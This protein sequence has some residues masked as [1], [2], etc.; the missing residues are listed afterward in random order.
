MLKRNPESK[1]AVISDSKAEE[2]GIFDDNIEEIYVD[3]NPVDIEVVDTNSVE[4]NLPNIVI[5]ANAYLESLRENKGNERF[6]NVYSN[7]MKNF[8]RLSDDNILHKAASDKTID[9][10]N[11]CNYKYKESIEQYNYL[12]IQKKLNENET[13]KENLIDYEKEIDFNQS[14]YED[15]KSNEYQFSFIANDEMLENKSNLISN[16]QILLIRMHNDFLSLKNNVENTNETE[17]ISALIL[18]VKNLLHEMGYSFDK[19]G[20]L[21]QR[22][23]Q[24]EEYEFTSTGAGIQEIVQKLTEPEPIISENYNVSVEISEIKPIPTVE[25]NMS[26]LIGGFAFGKQDPALLN[27][28]WG[29]DFVDDIKI[30]SPS[31]E[32]ASEDLQTKD[33]FGLDKSTPVALQTNWG[34]E[35]ESSVVMQQK[36]I[37]E[38]EFGKQDPALL[39]IDWGFENLPDTLKVISLEKPASVPNLFESQG[40]AFGEQE[41]VA[42]NANF[43]Y[44]RPSTTELVVFNDSNFE[45]GKQEYMILET[46]WGYEF[47]DYALI[48]VTHYEEGQTPSTPVLQDRSELERLKQELSQIRSYINEMFEKNKQ[49]L[50]NYLSE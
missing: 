23:Y 35:F 44:N 21:Y 39:N 31:I 8:H 10:L 12:E 46:N 45:F 2:L 42:L 19:L 25:E 9:F 5:K 4:W 34:Y 20:E 36:V 41:S 38:F 3:G 48:S 50:K 29:Y 26:D 1:I 11:S 47:D 14:I 18:R 28:D 15:L 17:K 6:I 13:I 16:L 40:F 30:T 22:T 32:E 49:T 37:Y 43:D 27:V 7:K 33:T 24:P